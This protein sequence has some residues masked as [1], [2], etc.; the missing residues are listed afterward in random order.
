MLF[1]AVHLTYSRYPI[2]LLSYML[3]LFWES[4]TIFCLHISNPKGLPL[5]TTC[6][7]HEKLSLCLWAQFHFGPPQSKIAFQP[8][9]NNVISLLNFH[10]KNISCIAALELSS[11]KAE[12]EWE[13]SMFCLTSW[14]GASETAPV[15]APAFVFVVLAFLLCRFYIATGFF[16][17]PSSSGLQ[18]AHSDI[19]AIYHP[20][21]QVLQHVSP[22]SSAE[23]AKR[24]MRCTV[25]QPAAFG[26]WPLPWDSGQA[27]KIISF[28]NP[29]L[30]ACWGG[31]C[32][33]D[34][35]MRVVYQPVDI[36]IIHL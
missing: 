5:K 6:K 4:P 9:S 24:N 13:T 2:S 29:W 16:P 20:S 7:V 32:L 19:F 17:F 26:V 31:S 8:S 22:A 28:S 25:L 10:Q 15:P 18:P 36:L 33:V 11:T 12:T 21:G 35:L 27:V 30:W 14:F 23:K 3:T 1:G 34:S